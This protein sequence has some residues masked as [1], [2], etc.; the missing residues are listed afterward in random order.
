MTTPRR[1]HYLPE[2]YLRNFLSSSEKL[3]VYE[4]GRVR[5]STPRNEATIR[6]LYA[7]QTDE[8]NNYSYEIWLS[9]E[10]SRV[11]SINSRLLRDLAGGNCRL[12]ELDEKAFLA[13]FMGLIFTRG[14]IGINFNRNV[15]GPASEKILR[16]AAAYPSTFKKLCLKFIDEPEREEYGITDDYLEQCRSEISAGHFDKPG[17]PDLELQAMIQTGLMAADELMEMNCQLLIGP[18]HTPFVT[19]DFP[20]V[21][22]APRTGG[23]QLGIGMAHSDVEVY[24]PLSKSVVLR[25]GRNIVAGC[26]RIRSDVARVI[27]RNTIRF[28]SRIFSSKYDAR[29]IMDFQ[30]FS[31]EM[32]P[33]E[34]CLIPA[35]DDFRN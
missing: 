12:L 26:G 34:N 32:R 4:P 25:W 23:L 7:F 13:R 33:G 6:D 27:N 17:P 1:H 11:A 10:E 22:G 15:A 18:K 28:A 19:G 35:L 5:S 8:G 29:L 30:H 24:F 31:A 2:F 16:E 20:I 21:T 14:P 9:K 3:Y